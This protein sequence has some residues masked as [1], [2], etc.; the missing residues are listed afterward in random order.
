MDIFQRESESILQT[1]KRLHLAVERAEGVNVYTQNG[2]VYTD[3]LA[4]I[5]VNA[6]GHSHPKIISAINDQAQ[7]FLHISNYFYQEP[8]II[9]AEKLKDI[10]GYDK[11]FFCNSGTEATEGAVKIARRFGNELNKTDIIAFSGGF[12]GRSYAALSMM[13]KPHYKNNMYPFLVNNKI[14][15]FNDID[16]LR[17]TINEETAAVCLEFLQ[18]EGGLAEAS[19]EFVRELWSLKNEYNFLVIADEVQCGTGRTGD[20]FAF[21]KYNIRPDVV[22]MAKGIGGGLPLGAILVKDELSNIFESGMHGTTFGGNALACAT[23]Y[24]VLEELRNGLLDYVRETGNYLGE[25]LLELKQ[26]YPEKILEVRGRGLMQGL[27]LSFDA[28]ELVSKLLEKKIIANSASDTVL[29]LIPPLIITKV[30]IDIL[31]IAIDEI[32]G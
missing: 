7:K 13:D 32:F 27:Q 28:N 17:S 9:L 6:L 30:D 22:T 26:R 20:F 23:G 18:G 2:E 31:Y 21:E 3:F 5:A 19:E 29:R 25:K 10:S 12:H 14:I 8:Q 15:K 24:V 1:Y 16:E 4:G 11:V